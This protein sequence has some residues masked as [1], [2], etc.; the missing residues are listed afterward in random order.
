MPRLAYTFTV[1]VVGI[2]LLVI[3][4]DFHALVGLALPLA[5]FVL[6]SFIVKRAGVYAGPETLHSLVGIVDLAAI[7][8]FGP[9]PGAWVPAVSSLLFVTVGALERERTSSR[10]LIESSLG[11]TGLKALMGV[12][13][14]GIYL[15]L[16]GPIPPH[17]L[18]LAD[19]FPTGVAIL[20][21]YL[22]DNLGWAIWE[23][24]RL[25]WSTF[26][27]LFR[28]TL[29]YSLLVELIPLPFATVIAVVYTVFG[30]ITRPIFLLM[31]A[32]LIEIAFVLQRFA[33]AQRDLQRR[34]Q[35]LVL[36]NEFGQAVAQA[37]FD[38]DRIVELFLEYAR[39][40]SQGNLFRLELLNAERDGVR[41]HVEARGGNSEWIRSSASSPAVIYL[42]D[43]PASIRVQ[44][45]GKEK[46]PFE[47]NEWING[48]P[49]RSAIYLPLLAAEEVIGVLTVLTTQPNRLYHHTAR[50]LSSMTTQAATAIENANLYAVERRRATQLA[51]V[52]EVSRQVA[53][54]LDLDE[55]LQRV[56]QE[57]QVRFGYAEVHILA[58]N[59]DNAL[60]F[61]ASTHPDVESWRQ[62]G[63]SVPY[64]QGIVGWVLAT[65]EPLLAAD[66]R[67]EPRYITGPGHGLKDT[68]SELAVPLTVGKKV[69]GV[70]DVQ[71]E[72][73]GRFGQEDL[74][75]L[76]TLAAQIAI[77]IEDAR[78]YAV[79][80]E[81][82]W[83]LN[84]LLQVSE[85]LADTA[86]LDEA[87]ETVVRI[88][89]ILV[90][91][92]RCA[93]FLYDPAERVLF[94]TK[95][96][97]IPPDQKDQFLRLRFKLDSNQTNELSRLIDPQLV[98]AFGI[99]SLVMNP[100]IY[101]G[102][103]V[104]AMLVDQGTRRLSPHEV[105]ILT[106]ISNQSAVAIE[107]ARL[108]E[109]AE[110]K[111]RLDYEIG[112]ARRIQTSF[113][114]PCCPNV[115]GYQLSATWRAA[116]EVSGDFYDFVQ[117]QNNRLGLT[118][119]DVSDKGMPAALFM[120][121]TRTLI[122]AMAIGRQ[123]P[124]EALERAN[125]LI[126]AD[127]RTDMFVTVF[128][129]VLDATT[130]RLRFAN[131]GHNPP[132]WYRHTT[133]DLVALKG[134][135]MALG[136]RAGI[137]LPEKSIEMAPGD[138]LVFYTDGITDALNLQEQEFGVPRLSD[139]I[140]A[141]NHLSAGQLVDE[142]LRAVYDFSQGAPQFDDMTL[143]VLKRDD[144]SVSPAA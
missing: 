32:G 53:Q 114:P 24:L 42:R 18:S 36:L 125:D 95:E 73:V 139:L 4:T 89:P 31:A 57:I 92:A 63:E 80:K 110:I 6:L 1:G 91:V 17:D 137:H 15:A 88:T 77:A 72:Q 126:L 21:W 97:G 104:G 87:L 134:H 83:Y 133:Q 43:N 45:L 78:L 143:I 52:S 51:I 90:G 107:N 59:E 96:Y 141:N 47:A 106:G 122:R 101:R 142:I 54:F 71:S 138:I 56:V 113:L 48:Q 62:Q 132:L 86:T 26:Y 61:R 34:R 27:R 121:L 105:Q 49:A 41:L 68:H 120:V 22:F 2:G 23:A 76:R 16:G 130:G 9:A 103:L 66:V 127:A 99:E 3:M 116:R 19:A 93:V 102:A 20:T 75:V 123:A 60:V 100:L 136:L 128:Y 12:A 33:Q 124:Q 140:I 135:G 25:G 14:G 108:N 5:V 79:Q 65:G 129:A 39:R 94:A 13:T 7:F 131:A 81:E 44:D 111:K 8:L 64:G 37:G 144:D 10:S 50:N 35:E 119:A 85:N 28:S 84:V 11:N 30:G 82:S 115:P 67:K 29:G 74:F 38:T 70:L 40:I 55:L 112:L 109:Q 58:R 118:I 46:L 69:L 98:R 117:F